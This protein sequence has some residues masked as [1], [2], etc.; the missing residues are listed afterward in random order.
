MDQGMSNCGRASW[1][2]ST[3]PEIRET[4]EEDGSILVIPIGS[5]EQHGNHL[6][7]G[8][9]SLLAGELTNR[10]A[11][12][13]ADEA[14]LLVAPT[15]WSGFSPHHLSFGGTMTGEFDTLHSFLEELCNSA[16]E[17]GFD[18][19]VLVNGHGGNTSLVKTVVNTVGREN[20]SVEVLG[21]TYFDLAKEAVTEIRDSD[22]GGM[23]H[24]GEFETSLMLHLFPDLVRKED[25][26]GTYL[27][28][29]YEQ[30]EKDLL[31]GGPLSVYRDFD[32]YSESGAIGDPSL[33]TSEKGTK[34]LDAVC[35]ELETLFREVHKR[36]R[37]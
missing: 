23:A 30:G 11:N 25:M 21:L 18:A 35:E 8:T 13:L 14:P 31:I 6:P 26:D 36:N 27:D 15:V 12:S 22:P 5:I 10:A 3:A 4:A 28:E 20:E 7:V 19:M 32:S 37:T 29:P 9:D 34:I 16:L 17:N 33:A 2:T 24:G 1:I